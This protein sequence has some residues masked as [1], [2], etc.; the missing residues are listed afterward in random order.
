MYE[1]L[2]ID[3]KTLD[4]GKYNFYL[5]V[6]ILKVLE[7]TLI[8]HFNGFSTPTKVQERLGTHENGP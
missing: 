8:E 7:S 2:G 1:F 3:I 6:L 4:D 5:T